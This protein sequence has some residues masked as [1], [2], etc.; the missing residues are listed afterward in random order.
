MKQ[1]KYNEILLKIA[2][3]RSIESKAMNLLLNKNQRSEFLREAVDKK[4]LKEQIVKETILID[5]T[6]GDEVKRMQDKKSMTYYC[7]TRKGLN[8]LAK[9][10]SPFF[11]LEFA[12]KEM[13]II[14][15][16]EYSTSG[17]WRILATSTAVMMARVAGA[18]FHVETF[19]VDNNEV[20]D[21]SIEDLF[22]EKKN[23]Y[24]L[25][26][27]YSNFLSES[28]WKELNA[29]PQISDG[30]EKMEF[31]SAA[32]CKLKIA[33]TSMVASAR[34]FNRGRY[35]GILDSQYKSMM[36]FVASPFVMLWDKWLTQKESGNQELW[37][38]THAMVNPARGRQNGTTAV[39]IVDNAHDFAYQYN[40]NRG[41][42]DHG[43]IFGNGFSHMYIV[44]KST[45]GAAFL[46]F[47]M[48]NY[49]EVFNE[50]AIDFLVSE[51]EA[52]R[53]TSGTN[54]RIFQL[55]DKNGREATIGFLMDAK[56]I[57]PIKVIASR[58]PDK[59]FKIFCREWQIDYYKRVLPDNVIYSAI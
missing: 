38:R 59:K 37:S 47:L 5:K 51:G 46:R 56:M 1:A 58:N 4:H 26:T 24:T 12:P 49:D 35:A 2:L 7:I 6:V 54:K 50:D 29:F 53:N 8:Y 52:K 16:G 15:G 19:S 32:E 10:V 44:P 17:R 43:S 11:Y 25:K 41:E 23:G 21:G 31:Y 57:W 55:I 45:E 3:M 33:N 22:E 9:T 34:D 30:D 20:D 18:D 42:E 28:V 36:I 27:Y 14:F 39:L 40:G 13:S 48:L